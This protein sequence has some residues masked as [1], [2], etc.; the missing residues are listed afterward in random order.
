MKMN[1][2]DTMVMKAE[3]EEEVRRVVPRRLYIRRGDLDSLGTPRL[4]W[5]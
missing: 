3:A 2:S 5:M 1:I 4:A